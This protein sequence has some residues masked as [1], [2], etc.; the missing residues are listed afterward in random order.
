MKVDYIIVG[1]GLAGIAFCEQLIANKKSFVVFDNSSQQSST[2]AGGLYN[3]VTLKRFTPVW[4]SKAQLALAIPMYNE[5]EKRL[6]KKF[7]YKISVRRRFTSLEEQNN[8]FARSD[9]EDL[10][11][12]MS[13]TIHKNTNKN[14]D[15]NFGFGEVLETGRIDT[16][17]LIL[18]YKNF[19]KSK[20]ILKEMEFDYSLLKEEETVINYNSI[21]AQHVVFAEGYGLKQNPYFNQLPLI[22]SK[23]ELVTIKAPELNLDFVL[24]SSVFIIPLG[25]NIYRIGSTYERDNKDNTVTEKAKTELLTKLKTIINCEFEVINQVAG[26]RPTVKDRR[27]LVGTHK[28]FKRLHVLNGLGT[29]GVMIGPYVAKQLFQAIEFKKDL[30]PV[31]NINRFA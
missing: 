20:N 4:E 22:G 1:C 17:Y 7:D 2:V 30:D 9:R 27:P 6:N 8:W 11:A 18:E 23:G 28:T 15:A 24:K 25:E 14:I 21:E 3:P 13:T 31:I 19:L 16:K 5:I 29:R 26:V 12:Y 10:T